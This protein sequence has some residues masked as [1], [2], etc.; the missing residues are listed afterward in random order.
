MTKLSRNKDEYSEKQTEKRMTDAVRRALE[1]PH[2]PQKE[3]SGKQQKSP[4]RKPGKA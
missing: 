2:K 1:T 3:I 4:G